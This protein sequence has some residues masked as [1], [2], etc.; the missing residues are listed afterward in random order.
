MISTRIELVQGYDV[1]AEEARWTQLF[2][3]GLGTGYS[4]LTTL[5]PF[6]AEHINVTENLCLKVGSRRRCGKHRTHTH[7]RAFHLRGWFGSPRQEWQTMH[8]QHRFSQ[9]AR[10]DTTTTATGHITAGIEDTNTDRDIEIWRP[11]GNT[12]YGTREGGYT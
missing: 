9:H 10:G 11:T 2:T 8:T 3:L 6:E 4:T 1:E 5:S 12:I 7:T